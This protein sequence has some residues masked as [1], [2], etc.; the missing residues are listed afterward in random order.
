MVISGCTE[1]CCA[2]WVPHWISPGVITKQLENND[3][4]FVS[5]YPSCAQLV[6]AGLPVLD[7]INGSE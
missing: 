1:S 7:V 5:N 3:Q 2:I 6:Y 4:L